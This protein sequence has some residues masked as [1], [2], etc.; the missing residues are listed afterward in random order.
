MAAQQLDG[1]SWRITAYRVAY[2]SRLATSE[3]PAGVQRPG[4]GPVLRFTTAGWQQ[5]ARRWRTSLAAQ[6]MGGRKW[7][8]G[9]RTNLDGKEL[10]RQL[11]CTL[12]LV[13]QRVTLT[14]KD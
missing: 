10:L 8:T 13:G 3:A 6:Q 4:E 9:G 2:K 14:Q 11:A 12:L 1:G 7:R 5:L